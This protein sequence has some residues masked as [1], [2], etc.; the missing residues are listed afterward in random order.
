MIDEIIATVSQRA[1]YDYEIICVNDFSPDHVYDVLSKLAAQN[2]KIKV[3]NLAKNMGK[4]AALLA[5]YSFVQG[6]YIIGVD[7]DYQCPVYELWKLL[8]PVEQDQCDMATA[9]YKKKN[10]AIWKNLGSKVNVWM[11]S[12]LLEKPATLRFENFAVVKR[13]VIDG[14]IKYTGPFP[15]LEGLLLQITRRVVMV[16]M[17]ER[18]RGDNQKTGFTFQRS[19]SLFLNG[20]T[21]FSVKPLR[22]ATLAG[23]LAAVFG[24]LLGIYIVIK[25]L[26]YPKILAGYT[27][28]IAVQ[29]FISGFILICLGLIGE[30]IGRIYICLNRAP[31]YVIKNTIN[32]ENKKNFE[33]EG[34]V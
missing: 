17:E 24:F 34:I 1:Q 26:L 15:Y 16:D 13:F 18:E 25:K 5:G 9:K 19:L 28:T 27:S 33:W 10:Q 23:F 7:D 29:L 14:L 4:H 22:I 6:D 21:A 8:E 12:F 32:I 20:F 2:S 30:Y 11:S 31:Q 3:I